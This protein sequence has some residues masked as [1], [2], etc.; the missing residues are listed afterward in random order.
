MC[1]REVGQRGNKGRGIAFH[2]EGVKE[3]RV[4]KNCALLIGLVVV[5]MVARAAQG[6]GEV[7]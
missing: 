3:D 1:L 6:Q 2:V 5:L 4:M 7:K